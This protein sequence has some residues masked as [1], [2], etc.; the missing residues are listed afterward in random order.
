[1]EAVE[2]YENN[3]FLNVLLGF[4]L[5]LDHLECSKEILIGEGDMYLV[6]YVNIAY[7]KLEAYYK[8]DSSK[9]YLQYVACERSYRQNRPLR[10]SHK[11]M[12]RFIIIP[13]IA[14]ISR[15]DLL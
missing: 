14:L 6:T 2:Y 12:S 1:M 11:K 8:T 15:I 7:K 9:V 10:S 5:L 3:A 13:S 4:N